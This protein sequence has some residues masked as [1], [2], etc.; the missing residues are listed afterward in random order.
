MVVY[1]VCY[2]L[3]VDAEEQQFQIAFWLDFLNSA[4]PL[5]SK[6]IRSKWQVMIVGLR[7]DVK[8]SSSFLKSKHIQSWQFKYT[9]LPLFTKEL[10]SISATTPQESVAKLL[11]EVEI[12]CTTVFQCHAVNIPHT[13][14]KLAT[15]VQAL[16]KT[17]HFITI[18]EILQLLRVSGLF[19]MDLTGL[20]RVL[21]YL[22]AI[23]HIV[24]L[25][26]DIVCTNPTIVPKVAAKFISPSKVRAKLIKQGI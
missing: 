5:S 10:F 4:L 25:D 19:K 24:M 9:N 11:Q 1:L 20:R 7:A 21:R 6:S 16:S 26:S 18:E 2:S 13:Y 14:R 12:V 23:G 8:H 17:E 15:F 3:E 22:H